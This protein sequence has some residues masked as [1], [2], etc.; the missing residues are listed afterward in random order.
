VRDALADKRV[1]AVSPIV[2]GRAVKGPLATMIPQLTAEPASAAAVARH[3]GPLV[4]AMV[5][6]CGDEIKG[7]R[8]LATRTVMRSR[9]DRLRLAEEALKFAKER[10]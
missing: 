1:L 5:V 9:D 4:S 10:L 8:C 7:V 6:E 2:G 3:Y